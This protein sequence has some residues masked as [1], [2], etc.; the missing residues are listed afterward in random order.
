MKRTLVALVLVALVAASNA[1]A[2]GMNMN[3]LGLDTTHKPSSSESAVGHGTFS[4]GLGMGSAGDFYGSSAG[5]A[6]MVGYDYRLN[7]QVS[8]GATLTHSSTKYSYFNYA[9]N[10]YGYTYSHNTLA[11][12]GLYHLTDF[13]DDEKLDVYS[14][15][16]M[17]YNSVGVSAYGPRAS[18]DVAKGSFMLFGG[19]AGAR[20]Q[21]Q[22]KLGGFAELG[23]SYGLSYLGIGYTSVLVGA[24]YRL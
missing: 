20:Y 12:R 15:A 1:F 19:F 14:G 7:E 8:V 3:P 23:Y 24:T 16:S 17:G 18:Q 9:G 22:P 6:M 5:P 10:E 11:L 13:V 21:F 2:G 4:A